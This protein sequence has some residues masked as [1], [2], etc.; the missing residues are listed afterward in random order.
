MAFVFGSM[1][2]GSEKPDSDVDLMIV[3]DVSL[4]EVS[5]LLSGV[6][7]TIGRDINPHV[8]SPQEFARRKMGR[9][10]FLTS[11]LEGPKLFVIGSEHELEAVV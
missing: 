6:G 8:Y 4:R 1:A 9:D 7:S 11:V 5:K 3:G 10:H 2:D